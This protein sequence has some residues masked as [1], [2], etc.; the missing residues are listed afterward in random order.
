MEE[1][2]ENLRRNAALMSLLAPSP[3]TP[4]GPPPTPTFGPE[5][6][7]RVELDADVGRTLATHTA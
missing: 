7:S 6:E 4:A 2:L 5:P 3:T 1:L